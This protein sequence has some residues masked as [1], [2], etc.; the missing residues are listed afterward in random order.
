MDFLSLMWKSFAILF[1]LCFYVYMIV[2][3][4]LGIMTPCTNILGTQEDA[5]DFDG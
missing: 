4:G 1:M 5:Q 3:C 2:S